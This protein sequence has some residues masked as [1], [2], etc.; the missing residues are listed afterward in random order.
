MQTV[1]AFFVDKM[2][3]MCKMCKMC[4]MGKMVERPVSYLPM[5]KLITWRRSAGLTTL[6]MD[7]CMVVASNGQINFVVLLLMAT[8]LLLDVTTPI[9]DGA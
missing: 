6:R 3:R 9:S 7:V 5:G 2:G 1:D 4:R 8:A